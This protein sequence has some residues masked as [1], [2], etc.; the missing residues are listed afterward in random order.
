MIR[1]DHGCPQRQ[2]L[3]DAH[4]EVLIRQR[5]EDKPTAR[6]HCIDH[7]FPGLGAAPD[8]ARVPAVATLELGAIRAVSK[9]H[10]L[11]SIW[12]QAGPNLQQHMHAFGP[13]DFAGK[14]D[15]A[16][17]RF[18]RRAR[19]GVEIGLYE[20]PIARQSRPHQYLLAE[21]RQHDVC[22]NL[23]LE[24][25]QPSMNYVRACNRP[26]LP[27][28]LAVA[29][30]PQRRPR[31][32]PDAFLAWCT[33]TEK[34]RVRACQ[35]E[36]VQSLYDRHFFT[37]GCPENAG[38]QQRKGVVHVKNIGRMAPDFF[39][40]R[41][42]A[43]KR[44]CRPKSRRQVPCGARPVQFTRPNRKTIHLVTVP[45]QKI[46]FEFD[47]GIF[48]SPARAVFIMNLK[49]FQWLCQLRPIS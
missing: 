22:M 17:P 34:Q 27:E 14:N 1:H 5:W 26:R 12:R 18:H 3:E 32:V 44:P 25:A 8:D 16:A 29:A 9:N 43:S 38:A 11:I 20:Y 33:R 46:G 28:R 10:E 35:A 6:A 19:V 7:F 13:R 4:G 2:S 23:F 48:S 36:I 31:K 47:D 49:N 40:D 41:G 21:F 24:R 30:V 42:I 37:R 45:A 15:P 39:L